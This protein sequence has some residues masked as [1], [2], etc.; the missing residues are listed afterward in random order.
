[1]HFSKLG[2]ETEEWERQRCGGGSINIITERLAAQEI[3][4][5]LRGYPPSLLRN[6]S[7]EK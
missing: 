4:K 3:D 1:M 6:Q 5:T 2:L 7:R